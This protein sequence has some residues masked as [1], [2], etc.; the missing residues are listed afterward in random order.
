MPGLCK[1]SD[2]AHVTRN[3]YVNTY[4]YI[5]RLCSNYGCTC[6]DTDTN[7]I[8]V[9]E[10]VFAISVLACT[11]ATFQYWSVEENMHVCHCKDDKNKQNVWSGEA[12]EY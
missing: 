10:P 3:M 11:Y 8:S 6:T 2:N 12:L 9:V 1:P 7:K 5:C 4:I